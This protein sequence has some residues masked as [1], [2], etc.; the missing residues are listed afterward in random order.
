MGALHSLVQ[1]PT[2][3]AWDSAFSDRLSQSKWAVHRWKADKPPATIL[4][5]LWRPTM[6]LN[7]P[8]FAY[9]LPVRRLVL[10]VWPH[11]DL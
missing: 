2:V 10:V 7:C 9:A 4:D 8:E 1:L 5:N 3:S 11:K 6:G